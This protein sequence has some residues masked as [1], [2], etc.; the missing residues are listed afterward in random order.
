MPMLAYVVRP[1]DRKPLE[2]RTAPISVEGGSEGGIPLIRPGSARRLTTVNFLTALAF[3][4]D[5]RWI[6][7]AVRSRA[8]GEVTVARF[9]V[10]PEGRRDGTSRD[11]P[12][13][14]AQSPRSA[15][16]GEPVVSDNSVV[17]Q[18]D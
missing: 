6:Y 8:D 9:A 18:G 13:G 12:R 5:G 2:L 4:P 1:G 17:S 16:G 11:G 14:P 3:S 15:L 7:A 10:P